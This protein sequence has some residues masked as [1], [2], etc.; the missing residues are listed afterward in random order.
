MEPSTAY[1]AK[2]LLK[3]AIRDH[4]PVLYFEHKYLYRRIKDEVPDDDYVVPIGKA[5]LRREGRDLSIIT[6]GAMLHMALD[7]ADGARR[8][9]DRGRSARPAEASRLSI[10]RRCS[11]PSARPAGRCCCTRRDGPAASAGE[12]AADLAEEAFEWL[13]GP[14]VRVA[15]ADTPVPYARRS[16]RRICQTWT[17]WWPPRSDWWNTDESD[18]KRLAKL[19]GAG[20]TAGGGGRTASEARNTRINMTK[21]VMPQMGESIAEGTIIRWMKKVGDKV[22]RDQ[23]LFEISTDKVDAEIPRPR[24]EPDRDPQ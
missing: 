9:R 8:G 20:A 7:A 5:A 4:D 22:E 12:V 15:S 16:K 19:A 24:P 3:A 18:R 6:F 13:D 10:R 14:V 21:V 2:G 23:P 1:D 11:R 17:S